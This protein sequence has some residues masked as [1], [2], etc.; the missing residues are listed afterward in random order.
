MVR[1]SD[2]PL[3]LTDETIHLRTDSADQ[4][5]I[6]LIVVASAQECLQLLKELGCGGDGDLHVVYPITWESVCQ[7]F[8]KDL[9]LLALAEKCER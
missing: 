8:L 1:L 3:C 4:F 7:A 9:P 5:V 6:K 2:L